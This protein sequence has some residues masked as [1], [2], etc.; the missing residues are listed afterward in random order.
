M[1]KAKNSDISK[2]L[3]SYFFINFAIFI[4]LLSF[5]NIS[6]IKSQKVNVLGAKT[7]NSYWINFVEKNP[8]YRDAWIELGRLD[9]VKEIDPNYGKFKN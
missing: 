8:T 4:L 6:N 2:D 5:F 3:K 9:K 1:F 7:D